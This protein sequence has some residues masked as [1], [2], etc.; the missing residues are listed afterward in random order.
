MTDMCK[1][2]V[3]ALLLVLAACSGATTTQTGPAGNEIRVAVQQ[4]AKTLDPIL[5]SNT[6]DVFI[7]RFMF[8]PLLSADPHGNPVPMLAAE[9]PSRENGGVSQDGL[10]ITY[11]LRKNARWTDGTPV[12]SADVKFSWQAIMNPVNNAVSRHGYDDV[13]RIDT[14]DPHTAVIR[15][16]E[17]F[18]PFI[19]TFFAESDQPYS[20]VPAH[21]L[22]K[23]PNINQVPFNSDPTVSD[24]PFRFER[25]VHGDRIVMSANPDFFMGKPRLQRVEVRVVADENTTVNLLRTHAVD[26]MYQASIATYPE[27]KNVPGVRLVWN[28]MNG[29]E[30]MGLNMQ[31]K[32]LDDPRVRLAIAYAI[33]KPQLVRTLTYG[34]ERM[35]TADLPDWMW[36]FNPNV[37]A[38]PHDPAKARALLRAAG[39]KTPLNLVM[40]TES[41]NVTHKR[42]AVQLQAMLRDIGINAE[43]K[44][45]PGD[46]LYAPAGAGGIVNGGNFDITIW[47]WYAGIDPDNSSQFTCRN[48]PPHG[49]NEARY[50]NPEMEG[51]QNQALSSYDRGVRTAAYH[52]IQTLVVRDNPIIAFWWQRQ[53]QAI[54]E[55]FKGFA[56]NP[57]V[58]SWNAW[59]WRI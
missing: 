22:A 41:A 8:E 26:Y 47:P 17:P 28:N 39:V 34:Q 42:T 4:D 37:N 21:V 59:Q 36:A 10:T 35:A 29:Y 16:K 38:Y 13:V 48:M 46:L 27:L 55:K 49:Y 2:A 33:D 53:Q 23:Y 32:P 40:V 1:Y 58:E 7:Q 14:P 3:A 15:L 57:V 50:C 18:S 44:T 30:G 43:L 19:N 24:G 5:A 54:S 20:I 56:P 12:S 45:Y 9:V 51:L 6:V 11:R 25:W 52:Q 31:H